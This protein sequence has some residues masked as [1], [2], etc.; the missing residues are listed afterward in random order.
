MKWVKATERL[1]SKPGAYFCID[2]KY[3]DNQKKVLWYHCKGRGQALMLRRPKDI[4]W[5][6]ETTYQDHQL[7]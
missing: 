4:Q 1:P 6:D 2:N 3:G 7:Y 5:L